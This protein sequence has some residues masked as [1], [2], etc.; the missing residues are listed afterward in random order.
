MSMT[1]TKLFSSITE[2]TIWSEP[3]HVRICWIT[4]MAMAD[5]KGRVWASVPGL[6]NRARVTVEHCEESIGRF[7]SPDKY[8]RTPDNDGIRIRDIEGGWQ[9][10]NY[11][12]YRSIREDQT[13]LESKSKYINGRRAAEREVGE[14]LG[15][16]PKKFAKPTMPEL[17]LACEKIELPNSEAEKFFNYYESKGWKVGKSPMV[18]WPHSL[19]NWKKNLKAWSAPNQ[20]PQNGEG[21]LLQEALG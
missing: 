17:L 3:D 19:A 9:L 4:M 20:N 7:K 11:E 8:S 12:K 5:R 6:A 2:S 1:F 18:S 10:L 16:K 14:A 21:D 13:S 15:E